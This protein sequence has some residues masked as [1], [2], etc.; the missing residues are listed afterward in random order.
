[1]YANLNESD[2]SISQP[3]DIKLELMEHQ[4][5]A[6][7]S[8]I[9]I[10][11]SS[12]VLAKNVYFFEN[13]MKDLVINTKIG[14]LGDIMGSGKSL[15]ILVLCLIKKT[16]KEQDM[17]YSSDKYVNIRRYYDNHIYYTTNLIIIP[18]HLESQWIDFFIYVPTLKYLV[19][20]KEIIK[21]NTKF[22]IDSD[23]DIILITSC[24][25]DNFV[26]EFNNI[27]W[28][29]IFID[30]ADSIKIQDH[31]LIANFIWL[32][33]GTPSG[34]ATS[35]SKYIKNIFG[36]NINWITD[37]LTVKNNNDYLKKSLSLFPIKRHIINCIT[38]PELTILK[39]FIPNSVI[40]MINAG[41]TENAIKILNCHV[42]TKDNIY[43][44]IKNNIENNIYNKKIEIEIE[45]KK[46]LNG[47]KLEESTNKIKQY[48][49]SIKNLE[50][51]L[52]AI[53]TKIKNSEEDICPVCMGQIETT[54]AL[55]NC[56]GTIFCIECL[57][58]MSK[59]KNNC[60]FCMRNID[61]NAIHI[62]KN[63]DNIKK[64]KFQDLKDKIDALLDIIS[65]S[66]GGILVFA[67][68]Q[69]TFDKITDV[70][71]MNKISNAILKGNSI[72]KTLEKF[73]KGQIKVLMLNA[74]HFGAGLNLQTATDVVI[75]HRF[76]TEIEEQVIGRAQRIGRTTPLNVH[77]LIHENESHSFSEVF[78]I[79]DIENDHA[80]S[81][82]ICN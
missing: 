16:V 53:Q 60:M 46:K 9:E 71:N 45:E 41:N 54:P 7:Y 77:Y 57:A 42:D 26:K 81:D 56:C 55:L 73:N 72:N 15:I 79:E 43:V 48:E 76:T 10:E 11:S 51:R 35:K 1:M 69:E 82:F 70:I 33:T 74:L 29:R 68:F 61:K 65:Q 28:N 63:N 58:L 12:N 31:E 5:K 66:S 23:I 47:I 24:V 49:K 59:G 25:F 20:N 37:A 3:S 40:Q 14:I 32:V 21:S 22:I 64:K 30:E 36:K 17:Y 6:I 8:M 4:K 52:K 27:I 50:S 2:K 44:V 62:V 34:I 18:E 38:P 13:K 39:E 80:L 75:Y 19:Y 67:N 78:S